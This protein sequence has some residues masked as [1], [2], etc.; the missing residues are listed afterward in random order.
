MGDRE[1]FEDL[2]G[3]VALVLIFGAVCFVAGG[4]GGT[5]GLGL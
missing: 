1:F 3:A 5:A 2:I 4:L